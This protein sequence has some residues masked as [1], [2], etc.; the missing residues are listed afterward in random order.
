LALTISGAVALGA[1]EGGALGALLVAVQELCRDGGPPPIRV[2]AMGGASAGSITAMLA[3]R[4]L[5]AGLDPVYVMYQAWVKRD[6]LGNM[7]THDAHAPLSVDAIRD[8]AVDLL[9]PKDPDATGRPVQ[10]SDIR[11]DMALACLR[12]LTYNVARLHGTPIEVTT[13]L[14]WATFTFT[15]KQT[16]EDFLKPDNASPLEFALASGA[17]EL[18]FPPRVLNRKV[19]EEDKQALKEIELVDPPKD[20][21][22]WL[23]YTDGGTIDNEPLGRTFDVANQVD[24]ADGG[25]YRRLHLLV[26]PHPTA[27]PKGQEWMDPD[28]QPPWTT[29]L[30]RGDHIQRTQN[31]FSDLRNAEKANSRIEWADRLAAAV[32]PL[33]EADQSGAWRDALAGVVAEIQGQKEAIRAK[34]PDAADA[35]AAPPASGSGEELFRQVVG[36]VSGLTG[37]QQADVHVV[38]PLILEEAKGKPVEELL[39][40]EFLG[41]FGGF[42]DEKLRISD[43]ALGYRSMQT[44]LEKYLPDYLPADQ[45]TPAIKAAGDGYKKDWDNYHFGDETLGS[46]PLRDKLDMAR[47]AVHM[48]RVALGEVIFRHRP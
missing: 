15:T 16:A 5:L 37:K 35:P 9:D 48:G 25:E 3:A 24:D 1:Y 2:D 43:F 44:W 29:T 11:V 36:L 47:L 40:G 22:G 23:W 26:H 32:T 42:L 8:M 39:A 14:D 28:H 12:G 18:G 10:P 19:R 20:W 34:K 30:I 17:N 13:Y 46:L 41:H 33:L 4:A 21:P 31:L 38:S 45:A 27:N 6:S 7:R